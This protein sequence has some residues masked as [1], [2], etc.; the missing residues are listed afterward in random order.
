MSAPLH[1]RLLRFYERVKVP[2]HIVRW[3]LCLLGL[4][5]Q[6]L[7]NAHALRLQ[8]FEVSFPGLP[9]AFDGYQLLMM[10]DLH[11]DS[12]LHL[13]PRAARIIA[14]TPADALVLVG[15]YRY[16]LSGP[17]ELV[18]KRIGQILAKAQVKDGIFAVRGNHDS[19]EMM[20]EFPPIGVRVLNNE[21]V[22]ITRDGQSIY[23]VGVD[24]PHYDQ[25]DDL[26]LA[27]I[28]IPPRAFK[29]LL[30]HTSEIYREA[31]SLGIN[32]YLCGHTHGGQIRFKKFG[33]L[34]TNVHAPRR[35]VQGFWKYKKMTGY[36][37]NGIGTSA[38]PVRFNCPPEIVLFTLRA[39]KNAV[40]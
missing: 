22:R 7:R 34:I 1:K 39:R 11:I 40:D 3:V 24:E 35:F 19:P 8:R 5:R 31:Q 17:Y 23:I 33:P 13:T 20:R 28:T 9:P 38:V 27:T 6:G 37:S 30:A 16:H 32:F 12:E 10:S 4:Y 25:A 18:F 21:N 29:I 36:T 26:P 2:R 15:D 14:A